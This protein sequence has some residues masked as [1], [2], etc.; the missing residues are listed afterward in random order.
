[1]AKN[2]LP[3]CI[4]CLGPISPADDL[5]IRV[6]A[7]DEEQRPAHQHRLC[8]DFGSFLAFNYKSGRTIQPGGT[9]AAWQHM[10]QF[11]A[12]VD[13]RALPN[14]FYRAKEMY[15]AILRNRQ[16]ARKQAE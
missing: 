2:A 11:Y 6:G 4:E 15:E 10:A 13:V 12:K 14:S 16:K 8:H 7:E 1:M 5:I 3:T 9:L